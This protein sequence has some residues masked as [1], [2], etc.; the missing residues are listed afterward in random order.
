VVVGGSAGAL[1]PLRKLLSLLPE[2]FPAPLLAVIHRPALAENSRL[3]EVVSGD[4]ALR[5]RHPSAGETLAPG[6]VYI[7]PP[8]LHMVVNGGRTIGLVRGPRENR[9]RPAIDPLFRTAAAAYGPRAVGVIL[10][11]NLSDGTAG[12]GWIKHYGGI[13]I[14][15][16][17]AEARLPGMPLRAIEEVA[18]DHVLGVRE[19][20]RLLG[21]LPLPLAATTDEEV[22]DEH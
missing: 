14:V 4:A 19:I 20:A 17:P 12:L 13:T 10:S 18:P 9:H 2:E 3:P 6:A 8:D 7:A 15:Q 5:A 22:K 21:E 16:D 1:E 11:G